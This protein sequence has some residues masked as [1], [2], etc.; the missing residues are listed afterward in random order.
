MN[1]TLYDECLRGNWNLVMEMLNNEENPPDLE[2]TTNDE[3]VNSLIIA[4][5]R[6]KTNVVKVREKGGWT[7]LTFASIHGKLN[8]VKY[9]LDKGAD[10]DDVDDHGWTP[11]MYAAEVGNIHIIKELYKRGANHHLR[12][13][14]GFTFLDHLKEEDVRNEMVEYVTVNIKCSLHI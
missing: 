14:K 3:G 13:D 2:A 1:T 8:V 9:L 6:G 10:I 12:D 5:L 11:M 4:C 7:P